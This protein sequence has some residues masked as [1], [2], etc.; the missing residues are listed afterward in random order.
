MRLNPTK[1]GG[2]LNVLYV[3]D[4]KKKPFPLKESVS[5]SE[6]S[7][8]S[9]VVKLNHPRAIDINEK[10][11]DLK[12]DLHTVAKFLMENSIEPYPDL[13]AEEYDNLL[14]RR[15]QDLVR[16]NQKATMNRGL[17]A[18]AKLELVD[19][20]LALG[21]IELER[22]EILN[23]K[24]Q[25]WREA[26]EY[27]YDI[28]S[29][30]SEDAALFMD[31]LKEFIIEK[32]GCWVDA[33]A[34][35]KNIHNDGTKK[36]WRSW[37]KNFISWSNS[38][39][40]SKLEIPLTFSQLDRSVYKSYGDYLMNPQGKHRMTDNSFGGQV[41][42]C[43]TFFHWAAN[44]KRIQVDT[45]F[46]KH[47][48]VL[49]EEKLII[50]LSPKEI[51]LLWDEELPTRQEKYR[52]LTVFGCLTSLRISDIKNTEGVVLEDNGFLRGRTMKNK[53]NFKVDTTL[54][55]RIVAIG[56]KYNWNLNL[57]SEQTYNKQIKK[58][59]ET[60]FKKHKI[61]SRKIQ[62]PKYRWGKLVKDGSSL[63]YKHNLFTSHCCRR[64][65][66]TNMSARGISDKAL[67]EMMGS[68][69]VNEFNKYKAVKVTHIRNEVE[70]TATTS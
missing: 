49:N 57:C 54:D 24:K 3:Y 47:W 23:Q 64:S 5:V 45:R 36:G 15:K 29:S 69:S 18:V 21:E 11:R 8:K 31:L 62:V 27:G 20:D 55:D 38:S 14:L 2:A 9:E 61:N 17:S 41:K 1:T 42:K 25:I 65:W 52:D 16:L 59:L 68:V 60:L 39:Y 28:G 58:I 70:R 44:E 19:A 7:I 10:I 51:D 34:E 50:S 4:R 56:E 67:M 12:N 6:W 33:S 30:Y 43:K 48:K 66:V 46:I 40:F 37:A 32:A 22:Q 26:E 63:E 53:G 13:V 35:E